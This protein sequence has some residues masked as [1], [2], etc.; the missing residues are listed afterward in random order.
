MKKSFHPNIRK[1]LIHKYVV[2]LHSDAL[3]NDNFLI[4]PKK[5]V[6]VLLNIRYL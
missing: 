2:A 4:V 1:N 3:T 5:Y 6:K